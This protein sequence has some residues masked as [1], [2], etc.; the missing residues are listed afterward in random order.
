MGTKL[1]AIHLVVTHPDIGQFIARKITDPEQLADDTYI[2][3]SVANLERMLK[4]KHDW[5]KSGVEPAVFCKRIE[6]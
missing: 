1:K 6:E 5:S 2:D 3:R 4:N